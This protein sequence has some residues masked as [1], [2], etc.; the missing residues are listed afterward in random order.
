MA[1]CPCRLHIADL[2]PDQFG[3]AQ[4]ATK[5]QRKHGVVSFLAH[6][7]ALGPIQYLRALL[8]AEPVPRALPELLHTLH[9][10]DPRRQI[11]TEQPGVGSLVGQ[12]ANGGQLLVDGVGGQP[13][14]F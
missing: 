12:P 14:R 3:S 7:V 13:P 11:G 1:Q 5:Q 8:D 10:A 2:Q 6:T 4:P 9:A